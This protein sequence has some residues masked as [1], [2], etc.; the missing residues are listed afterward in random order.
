MLAVNARASARASGQRGRRGRCG[1]FDLG[2]K[3][4]AMPLAIPARWRRF[5]R[6]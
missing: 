5:R 2:E 3:A 4:E 6:L 1:G